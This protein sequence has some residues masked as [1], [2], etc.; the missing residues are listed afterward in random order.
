MY[1]GY[2]YKTTNLRT[3]EYYIGKHKWSR[4]GIDNQYYGSGLWVNNI[5]NKYPD[6][7]S[8]LK[9]EPIQHCCSEIELM[10][11][12]IRYICD[13]YMNPLNKNISLGV[14]GFANNNFK[15]NRYYW[16]NI[17]EDR[18]IRVNRV[19]MYNI[20]GSNRS[21]ISGAIN[22]RYYSVKDWVFCGE[23]YNNTVITTII[24]MKYRKEEYNKNYSDIVHRWINQE[25][26]LI[27]KTQRQMINFLECSPSMVNNVIK[28]RKMSV[29]GWYL[30]NQF[31]EEVKNR[32]NQ[33]SEYS[34]SYV[35]GKFNWIYPC[36]KIV[37]QKTPY[38]VF[39]E[40]QLKSRSAVGKVS[41]G[42]KESYR[43]LKLYR[44]DEKTS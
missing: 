9:V 5:K 35:N 19:E 6:Y 32:S 27:E 22:G 39:V 10:E 14:C 2:V 17:K 16:Y 13:H 26:V 41:R 15:T 21:Q 18:L 4:E 12:E 25:G 36:G 42:E 44:P 38:E 30:E 3:Q 40:L 43:G 34:P 11:T 20:I 7:R 23:I 24:K 28:G 29:K 37:L 31:S 8:F 1:I 33:K